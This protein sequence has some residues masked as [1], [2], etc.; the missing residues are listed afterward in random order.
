M[1]KVGEDHNLKFV[2]CDGPTAERQKPLGWERQELEEVWVLGF[3]GKTILAI[4]CFQI[5]F[6]FGGNKLLLL[7]LSQ[8]AKYDS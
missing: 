5:T 1:P 7:Y 4:D 8:L 3:H 6:T 2:S